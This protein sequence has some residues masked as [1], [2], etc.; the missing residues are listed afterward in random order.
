[1]R[2][3]NHLQALDGKRPEN[4]VLPAVPEWSHVESPRQ[5][6]VWEVA[7]ADHPDGA[8]RTYL[9]KGLCEGF[10]IGFGY[11]CKLQYALG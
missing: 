3:R 2:T 11:G 8:Y 1:M 9:V 10:R 6:E 5:P 7:L 4:R